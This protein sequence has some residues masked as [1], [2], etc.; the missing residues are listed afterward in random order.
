MR[1]ERSSHISHGELDRWLV[2]GDTESMSPIRTSIETHGSLVLP[3]DLQSHIQRYDEAL[4]QAASESHRLDAVVTLFQVRE[5]FRWEN[6]VNLAVDDLIT[7]LM[8]IFLTYY[9]P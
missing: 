1:R 6:A 4:A 5:V 2:L 3:S 8:D 9:F 7:D